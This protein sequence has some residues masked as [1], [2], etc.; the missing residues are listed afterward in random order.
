MIK[1]A[2]AGIGGYG[3]WHLKFIKEVCEAGKAELIAVCEPFIDKYYTNLEKY[4]FTHVNIYKDFDDM[5]KN[6]KKIDLLDIVTPI[7]LHKEMFLKASQK[8]LTV[9]LEKPPAVTIQDINIMIAEN[10]ISGKDCFVNFQM[11]KCKSFMA[12]L[13]E[14]GKIGEL[15]QVTAVGMWRRDLAYFTRSYWTGKLR[16][17][18]NYILDGATNNPFAHLLNNLLIVANK[19]I[20]SVRSE[21]YH[22]NNIEG[23]D[24]SGIEIQ[25]EDGLK[26]NFYVTICAKEDRIPYILATGQ[27]GI[28][29]W[30]T[31]GD[32]TVLDKKGSIIKKVSHREHMSEDYYHLVIDYMNKES[33][34]EPFRLEESRKFVLA[35][36][37]AFKSSGEIHLIEDE[38]KTIMGEVSPAVYNKDIENIIETVSCKNCLF[39]DVGIPWA[40]KTEKYNAENFNK[41]DF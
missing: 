41:F 12:F 40:K 1:I 7:P 5:L 8:G 34:I 38:Y 33:E 23:D 17:G 9:L 39:S 21:L 18:N 28:A 10:K 14:V 13:K 22:A 27:N 37:L 16:I 24:L 2:I 25:F 29:K 36:N 31:N 35:S 4:N 26:A 11:S 6:E 3:A 19:E 32:V 20:E 30:E 15:K